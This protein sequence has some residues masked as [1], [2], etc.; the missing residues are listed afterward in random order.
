MR[1]GFVGLGAMGRGLAGRL[2]KAGHEVRAWNRTPPPPDLPGAG[3][4]VVPALSD[5]AAS[6]VVVSML[7]HDGAVREVFL[8]G[9]L[10]ETLP[11]GAVHVNMAT[12]SVA[13]ARELADRHV[14][15][16]L[17]YV[18]APV[19][20][21]PDAAAE[22]RLHLLVAGPDAA[23]ARLEGLWA[24]LGQRVW[25]FGDRPESANGAKIASN[26]AL[27]CAIEAMGEAAAL[28]EAHGVAAGPYLEML[29]ATLFA[30]PAFKLY[31]TLIAEDRFEPAGFRLAHGLKDV[32]LALAAGA[33][34]S[35]PLA[36]AS[37][38]RDQFLDCLAHGEG[39]R[40]WSAVVNAGRRRA[41]RV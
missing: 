31:G 37:I 33:E 11:A 7:A 29:T 34:A 17:A 23:I 1:I 40:D 18:A 6:E 27:A 12:V 15:R 32:N 25:R 19:L 36:F 5:L 20:G 24:V 2:A 13:L 38:M 26:L 35:L 22:G 39:D 8:E 14:A 41:G 9:G 30:S 3:V 10:L 4:T 28:A 16:G 21:R